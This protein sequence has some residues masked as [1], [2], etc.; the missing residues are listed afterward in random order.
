MKGPVSQRRGFLFS[1]FLYLAYMK[2]KILF[3]FLVFTSMA[4][5]QESKNSK[6]EYCGIYTGK[7]EKAEKIGTTLI[8]VKL[9][10]QKDSLFILEIAGEFSWCDSHEFKNAGKWFSKESLLFFKPDP[11][12]DGIV[13]FLPEDQRDLDKISQEDKGLENKYAVNGYTYVLK[14]ENATDCPE[15]FFRISWDCFKGKWRNDPIRKQDCK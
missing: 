7:M 3:F 14:A 9:G 4:F 12:A 1:G 10:L 8:D 13:V 15:I 11:N 6:C 5:A 2:L